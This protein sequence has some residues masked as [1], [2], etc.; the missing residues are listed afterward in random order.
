MSELFVYLLLLFVLDRESFKLDRT[1]P[2][3]AKSFPD[4]D[5]SRDFRCSL[6]GI[7][8]GFFASNTNGREGLLLDLRKSANKN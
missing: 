3:C 8:V 6:L 2:S 5:F 4:R 1:L 7:L